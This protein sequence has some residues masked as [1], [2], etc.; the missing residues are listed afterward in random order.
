[1]SFLPI[2]TIPHLAHQPSDPYQ[3]H[4]YTALIDESW[5]SSRQRKTLSFYQK[6]FDLFKSRDYLSIT[7]HGITR[8]RLNCC[9]R[10]FRH[11]RC[12]R[13]TI[14]NKKEKEVLVAIKLDRQISRV[15]RNYIRFHMH[16][17]R[18]ITYKEVYDKF[19][20]EST[21]DPDMF[22][23]GRETLFRKIWDIAAIQ[24]VFRQHEEDTLFFQRLEKKIEERA[25]QR[26]QEKRDCLIQ[27]PSHNGPI[28]EQAVIFPLSQPPPA[29]DSSQKI[30]TSQHGM[31]Q[32]A[33]ASSS[34][35][36]I[37]G[38]FFSHLEW[39][40][41]M[42][43]DQLTRLMRGERGAH[44]YEL[45]KTKGQRHNLQRRH[46]EDWMVKLADNERSPGLVMSTGSVFLSI[47]RNGNRVDIF[48]QHGDPIHM[49]G[50]QGAYIFSH[51]L[52]TYE[53][54]LQCTQFICDRLN[55]P[56]NGHLLLTYWDVTYPQE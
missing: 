27:E 54:C 47:A 13:D 41:E 12:Y 56:L 37:A 26:E 55:F 20:A 48:D 53:D 51:R 1:M 8:K 21:Y 40:K 19:V 17:Q 2:R 4:Q 28:K 42:S 50:E 49:N 52:T 29:A 15:V 35:F 16:Q 46:I 24:D 31:H 22:Q 11:L 6:F 45:D 3:Y 10:F 34:C 7:V 23:D 39:G 14:F 32:P 38:R 36:E 44:R 30:I 25:T 33:S 9:Q 43:R 5:K 18:N